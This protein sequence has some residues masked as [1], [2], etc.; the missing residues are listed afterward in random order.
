MIHISIGSVYS[1]STLTKPLMAEMDSPEST[2]KWA[3]SIAIFC[4]G[5]SAAGLGK[6]VQ[7]YGPRVSARIAGACFSGGMILGGVAILNHSVTWLFVS[8]GVLGGVG[9]GTGYITPVKTLIRWFHDRKGM[10]TGLAVMGFGFGSVIAGPMFAWLI[11][12][13]SEHDASGA[14]SAY[15]VAPAFFIMGAVYGVILI[16]ASFIIRVPPPQWGEV[17]DAK[18]VT[19]PRQRQYKT[20][21]ALRTW[22]FYA[23]WL[24]LFVNISC[25]IAIIYTASPMM[26]DKVGVDPQSAALLAVSGVALFNGL[27]RFVWA[28]LSDK[29]GRP[30]TF[31]TFFVLQV[32]AFSSLGVLLAAGHARQAIFLLLIY[33]IATC[34]G[35]GFGTIPAY[36][37]DLFGNANVSAI[38]GWVLTA[39]AL[40]GVAGPSIL[41]WAKGSHENY[42]RAMVFYAAMLAVA[43]VVSVILLVA[44]RRSRG[45]FDPLHRDYQNPLAAGRAELARRP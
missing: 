29:M 19:V 37:S 42:Q 14:I 27:G 10:A 18:G 34:Y 16:A 30:F 40:A 8:Y 9:L 21:E 15:H 6:F 1:F 22:Q 28:S 32:V 31:A 23:L 11:G 26:Q 33:A 20:S 13:F 38:H 41:V 12:L 2:I 43:L 44:L 25:G 35:G 7:D 4:L 17:V 24:M 39:W 45:G 36:L 3:F 5:C